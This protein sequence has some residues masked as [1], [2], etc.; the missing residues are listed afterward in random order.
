MTEK[1]V[2]PSPFGRMKDLVIPAPSGYESMARKRNISPNASSEAK[3]RLKRSIREDIALGIPKALKGNISD[4]SSF[5]KMRGWSNLYPNGKG[6][7]N[8]F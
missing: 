8:K 7:T 1:K 2:S 6:T 3:A 5:Y 4:F